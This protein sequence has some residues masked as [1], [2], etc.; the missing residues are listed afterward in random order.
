VTDRTPPTHVDV[1]IIGAGISG[2][3]AG[4]HLRREQPDKS[5]TILEAR[6]SIGGTWDLFRYPGI[7]SD[8]D[9]QTFGYAFKPWTAEKVIAPAEEILAYLHETVADYELEKQIHYGYRVISADFSSADARWTVHVRQADGV[10]LELTSR[11][12]FAATGYYDYDSGFTPDFPG[13]ENFDGQLIHPQQWPEDLDWTGQ[14]IV[15]IGSGA[16]AVTLIPALADRARSVTMLQRSPTYVISLPSEDPIIAGLKK[17]MSE[18][19]AFTI[20]RGFNIRRQAVF[21]S[22]CQKYPKLMRRIIRAQAKAQLPK[23]FPVDV[24]FKPTYDPWDQRLCV[25][26]NGDLFKALREGTA[27]I[28]TDR[29]AHFEADGIK[30]DSGEFLPADIVIS[31][32]GL[33][34]FLFGGLEVSVDGA[35]VDLAQTIA[36][37]AMMLSGIPNFAYAIGYTNASWT[38]KVDLV[39]EHLG[40]I[41]AHLDETGEEIFTPEPRQDEALELRPLLDFEAGYVQRAVA[42]FPKQATVE[43][44]T[45]SMSYATDRKRLIDGPVEDPELRFS[46]AA[47]LAPAR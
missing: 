22:A 40:R 39:C 32:T 29:I 20:A 4:A 17:V 13:A 15:V 47:H 38:L 9:L 37:K 33:N 23:D 8:S 42:K 27:S 26:P 18:Q 12:L 5:F 2:I 43:P 19:R 34:V 31:A 3:G 45:V 28:V 36:Y 30:L 6:G 35:A 11:V 7:R 41:L 16:T 14:R 1:L 25:V 24:H 21:Y 10:E 44:W 46:R